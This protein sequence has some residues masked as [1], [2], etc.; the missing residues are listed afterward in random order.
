[1]GIFE[2]FRKSFILKII[3][4]VYLHMHFPNLH[5]HLDVNYL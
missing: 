1:M 3:K 2:K 5:A 4:N